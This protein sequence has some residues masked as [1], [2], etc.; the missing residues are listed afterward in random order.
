[1]GPPPHLPRDLHASLRMFSFLPRKRPPPWLE[2]NYAASLD[3]VTLLFLLSLP[4]TMSLLLCISE[5][6]CPYCAL[7]VVFLWSYCALI[8]LSLCSYC[9]LTVLLLCS[10]C[11]LTVLLLCSHC[12]L[13]MLLLCSHCALIMLSLCSHCPHTVAWHCAALYSL[14]FASLLRDVR[15]EGAATD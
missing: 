14:C 8:V 5:L 9:A 10:H 7:I 11:A 6:M 4:L 12:A 13:I 2:V 15:V 3:N 1:M